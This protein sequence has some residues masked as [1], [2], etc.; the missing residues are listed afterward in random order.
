MKRIYFKIADEFTRTPGPRYIHEG[1]NSAEQFLKDIFRN[2]F[3]R[4]VE[5]NEV[6]DVDLDDTAGYATSFLEGTFG[7]LARENSISLVLKHIKI[8][9]PK[10][11]WYKEEVM[12]YINEANEGVIV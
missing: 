9:S 2:R 5:N 3:L 7:E 6:I 11:P 12:E 1:P 10:K 8:L 4:A